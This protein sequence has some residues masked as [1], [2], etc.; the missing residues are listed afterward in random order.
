MHRDASV[1]RL[2]GGVPMKD[3]EAFW[4]YDGKS[5]RATKD[6]ESAESTERET[7]M[8]FSVSER[9]DDGKERIG[10]YVTTCVSCGKESP[11]LVQERLR[12]WRHDHFLS[13]LDEEAEQLM[14][15]RWGA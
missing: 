13:H 9:V 1:A 6:T 15:E 11:A 12:E 7:P 3:H 14:L 5:E 2:G 8:S 10:L 4:L